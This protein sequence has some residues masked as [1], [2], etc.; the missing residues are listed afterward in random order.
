MNKSYRVIFNEALG[1]WVAVSEIESAKGKKSRSKKMGIIAAAILA[2]APGL[3]I[4][5]YAMGQTTSTA[6]NQ[7]FVLGYNVAMSTDTPIDESMAIGAYTNAQVAQTQADLAGLTG[8]I[9]MPS[10][11][12]AIGYNVLTQALQ[13]GAVANAAGADALGIGANVLASSNQSS[14]GILAIGSAATA[15]ATQSTGT[16]QTRLALLRLPIAM[17]RSR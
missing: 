13:T 10:T 5:P 12:I 6:M 15:D 16:I 8:G 1:A 11:S 9:P 14:G 3:F 7:S 4:S 2:V 17:V